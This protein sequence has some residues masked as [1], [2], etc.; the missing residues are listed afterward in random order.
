MHLTLLPVQSMHLF[1]AGLSWKRSPVLNQ[2]TPVLGWVFWLGAAR[3]IWVN[4]G[5]IIE[6]LLDGG[7]WN[8][9][10][11]GADSFDMLYVDKRIKKWKEITQSNAYLSNTLCCHWY[12]VFLDSVFFHTYNNKTI[13]SAL[14]AKYTLDFLQDYNTSKRTC[15]TSAS[16]TVI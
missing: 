4:T 8:S 7:I 2:C 12:L 5:A 10:S 3:S 13:L 16:V 9:F 15:I 1:R 14:W 6:H 11:L